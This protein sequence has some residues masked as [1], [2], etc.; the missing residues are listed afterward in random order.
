MDF[1]HDEYHELCIWEILRNKRPIEAAI[2]ICS[3]KNV[4][5]KIS[6]ILQLLSRE[7]CEMFT[8]LQNN[9]GG[10]FLTQL[11]LHRIPRDTT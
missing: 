6:Q 9:S 3:S 10:C 8:F 7:I 5:L 2:R 11:L 1:K 4:F